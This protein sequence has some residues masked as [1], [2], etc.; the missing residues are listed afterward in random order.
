MVEGHG[1]DVSTKYQRINEDS[2]GLAL[3]AAVGIRHVCSVSS[4]ARS[5]SPAW[6]RKTKVRMLAKLR[7]VGI[8]QGG[9]LP[10]VLSTMIGPTRSPRVSLRSSRQTAVESRA[11]RLSMIDCNISLALVADWLRQFFTGV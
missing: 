6:R 1:T 5:L 8:M 11:A 9:R 2:E 4:S 3:A 7:G 10:G